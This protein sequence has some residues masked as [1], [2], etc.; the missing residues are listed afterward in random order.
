LGIGVGWTKPLFEAMNEDYGTRGAHIEEQ[1]EVLR[2]LWTQEVVTFEGRWHYIDAMRLRPLP[3]QRPIPIWFGGEADAVIRRVVASGDGWIP[4]L[5]PHEEARPYVEKLHAFAQA[6]GRDL[7]SIGVHAFNNLVGKSP[8]DWRRDAEAW[9][10]LGA[11]YLSIG[12]GVRN[13]AADQL[14]GEGAMQ[15]RIDLLRRFMREVGDLVE[16]S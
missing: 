5:D 16:H 11:T 3:K 2:A 10:A 9:R 15:K 7:Q 14:A 1:V 4:N 12:V 13:R 6:A 8:D